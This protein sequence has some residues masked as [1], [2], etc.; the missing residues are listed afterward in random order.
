MR[1][2]V[3]ALEPE[4]FSSEAGVQLVEELAALEKSCAAAAV[5]V[6]RHA[7]AYGAHR[8]QGFADANDWVASVVGTTSSAA[9]D[10]LRTVA[11]VEQCPDTR[12]ALSIGSVSLAQ[13]AE[14]VRTEAEVPGSEH[15][16]LQ[17]ARTSSL[18]AVRTRARKRRVEAIDVE[19]LDARQHAAR[20]LTHHRDELG[21]VCGSFRLHPLVGIPFVNRLERATDRRWREAKRVG[22][23]DTREALAADAFAEMIAAP[24]SAPSG[25]LTASD[26]A[27]RGRTR[28]PSANAD[29]VI[30]QSAEVARRGHA[31]RG[32]LCH[33]VGGGPVTPAAVEDLIAAGAFV[34]AL[35]HDGKQV[36]HVVHYGRHLT[37]EMRT[38]RGI[39]PPP[40]FDGRRCSEDGC[41]RRLGLETDHLDPLANGGATSLENLG[42]KCRQHHQ[43][44]TKCDRASGRL[45]SGP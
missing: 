23:A 37:A 25:T 6:A 45:R 43:E 32:E 35:L 36:T 31:H 41:E 29:V 39:G 8:D 11:D 18:G 21:M 3:A 34:N 28:R 12:D 17:L 15:E 42:D 10:A 2:E 30:V 5:R 27:K 16:L 1:D 14:I 22:R 38:A 33:I 44:K 9:R 19:K 40:E 20:E 7:S 26:G 13:A 4:R 24:V